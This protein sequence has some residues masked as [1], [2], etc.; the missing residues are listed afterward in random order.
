MKRRDFIKRAGQ[1]GGGLALGGLTAC[2]KLLDFY[3]PI[4]GN[5]YVGTSG[6]L[7]ISTDGG[8]SFNNRTN[9]ND[10]GNNNVQGV[11]VL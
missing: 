10:L 4:L 2:D 11:F 7:S 5:V 3:T 9:A 1:V 8:T 6:G